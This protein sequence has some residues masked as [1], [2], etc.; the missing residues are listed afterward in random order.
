M[1]SC[2]PG[3]ERKKVRRNPQRLRRLEDGAPRESW[4]KAVV[5]QAKGG[6]RYEKSR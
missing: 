5:R 4:G 6:L 3:R 2:A 1:P